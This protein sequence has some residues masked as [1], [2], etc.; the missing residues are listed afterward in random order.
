[1][2]IHRTCLIAL[3]ALLGTLFGQ[4]IEPQSPKTVAIKAARLFDGAGDR[5]LSPAVVIVEGS[6]IVQIGTT[7]PIPPGTQVIDLGDATLLPGFM[8]AHT[9][10]SGEAT[11]DWKQDELDVLKKPVAEQ[12]LDATVHVRR[13]RTRPEGGRARARGRR[14][15]ACHPCGNR[16]HRT[17]LV[18]G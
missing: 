11:D 15:Q 6:R 5:L 18:P 16:L 17:R 10:L 2:S 12:A 3:P 1:M 13:T 9:H 14:R 8:D 4:S 7:A